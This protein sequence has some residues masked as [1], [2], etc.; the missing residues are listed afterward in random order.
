M[1]KNLRNPVIIANSARSR[2][3]GTTYKLRDTFKFFGLDLGFGVMNEGPDDSYSYVGDEVKDRDC[4]I[5]S[6]ILD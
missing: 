3:I 2:R 6:E 1:N 5:I 4:L